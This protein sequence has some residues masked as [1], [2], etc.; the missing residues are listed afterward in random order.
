MGC[1]QRDKRLS[2]ARQWLIFIAGGGTILLN[3]S[4][5]NAKAFLRLPH[6]H[7]RARMSII[8]GGI[9]R[10]NQAFMSPRV[11][12]AFRFG[13][14]WNLKYIVFRLRKS[15][16]FSSRTAC[17]CTFNRFIKIQNHSINSHNDSCLS[18][19]A[20]VL[21]CPQL[22]ISSPTRTWCNDDLV[23]KEEGTCQR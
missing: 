19:P 5:K 7:T 12:R 14:F 2:N 13:S 4:P 20:N 9:V 16:H 15:Q 1:Y 23:W 8:F 18:N 6:A 11:W 10:K 22:S 17:R 3:W 21:V